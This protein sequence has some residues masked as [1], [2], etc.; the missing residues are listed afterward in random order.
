MLQP[1]AYSSFATSSFSIQ[2]SP[3]VIILYTAPIENIARA[4]G[5]RTKLWTC[6][7]ACRRSRGK[8][9]CRISTL[10]LCD[11]ANFLF[12]TISASALI[13][14]LAVHMGLLSGYHV[15]FHVFYIWKFPPELWRIPS[16]FLLTGK[17][18]GL[19]FDTYFLYKY[20]SELEIANRRF[21]RKEDLIWYLF[22]VS[23]GILVSFS[24]LLRVSLFTC[25]LA[26]HSPARRSYT[27]SYICPHS[28]VP[29]L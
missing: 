22:C 19:L 26:P 6:F 7:G 11:N 17:G 27:P 12:R 16:S 13:L 28:V 14:S 15:I 3:L 4:P 29:Q 25:I 23:A 10:S 21:P 18:L 5:C 20:L 8:L 24:R 1:A 9:P 2:S